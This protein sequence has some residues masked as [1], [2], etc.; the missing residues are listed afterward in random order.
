MPPFQSQ[1]QFCELVLVF[2]ELDFLL[3][4]PHHSPSALLIAQYTVLTEIQ[5][6]AS[7]GDRKELMFLPC[8]WFRERMYPQTPSSE[9]R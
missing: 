5:P 4:A 9:F 6:Q 2:P 8:S 7:Q 1:L 3:F